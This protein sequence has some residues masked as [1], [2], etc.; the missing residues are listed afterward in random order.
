MAAPNKVVVST[1]PANGRQTVTIPARGSTGQT[2]IL[3]F[4]QGVD[5]TI[6]QLEFDNLDPKDSAGNA[7][8]WIS[9]FGVKDSSGTNYI[10]VNYTVFVPAQHPGTTFVYQDKTGVNTGKTPQRSGSKQPRDNMLQ[11][12]FSTGDPG[13][14][15]K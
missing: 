9:N 3:D 7:I 5:Y 15:W 8:T 2:I 4:G 11:V 1:I 12:D 13:I 10:D 6:V 14:G